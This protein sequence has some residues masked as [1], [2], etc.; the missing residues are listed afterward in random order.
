MQFRFYTLIEADKRG[1]EEVWHGRN[2]EESRDPCSEP[3]AV[4]RP[5][6]VR[7]QR[8]ERRKWP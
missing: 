2:V 4:M 7:R 5:E 3:G 6:A 1:V 8:T